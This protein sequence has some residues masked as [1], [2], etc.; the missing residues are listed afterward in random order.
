MQKARAA[1]HT[2]QDGEWREGANNW[3][4]T[5]DPK[6]GGRGR[7]SRGGLQETISRLVEGGSRKR[8]GRGPGGAVGAGVGTEDVAP[9]GRMRGR[10]GPARTCEGRG[11]GQGRAESRQGREQ[12]PGGPGSGDEAGRAAARGPG[13]RVRAGVAGPP[14]TYPT[15]G[16]R[17]R[18]CR[19]AGP[20]GCTRCTGR[21]ARRAASPRSGRSRCARARPGAAAPAS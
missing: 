7:I 21:R 17:P 8:P 10:D 19:G 14:V 3:T 9:R 12:R 15:R 20:S 18:T 1:A 5:R 6:G 16:T 11:G 13:G 4:R 2:T